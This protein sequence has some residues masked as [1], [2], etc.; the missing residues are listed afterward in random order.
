M[1]KL[2]FAWLVSVV[3][4]AGSLYFS[5]VRHFIP[6][7]LCW[8][9]RICMYPIPLLLGMALYRKETVIVPYILPLS[10]I[11]GTISL[12]HYLKQKVPQFDEL[13]PCQVGVPC[14]VEYINWFGFITIPF[15]ALIAFIL[16]TVSLILFRRE[17]K[18]NEN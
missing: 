18:K 1:N 14:S 16:I 11:G 9:Q 4:M 15:L 7:T 12:I 13:V 3:A 2:R 5:E 8:F 17:E 6:C 10:V